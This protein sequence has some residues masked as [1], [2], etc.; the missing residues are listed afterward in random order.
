[1]S[2]QEP[3]SL[4]DMPDQLDPSIGIIFAQTFELPTNPFA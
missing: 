1:M 4:G 2:D 3:E